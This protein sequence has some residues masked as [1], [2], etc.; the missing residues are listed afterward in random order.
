MAA[1]T[2]AIINKL[3][4]E[5][6]VRPHLKGFKCITAA[7]VLYDKDCNMTDL[8]KALAAG[9]HSTPNRVERNINYL[10]TTSNLRKKSGLKSNGEVIAWLNMKYRQLKE[11][12][13]LI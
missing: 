8:Y 7:I 4:L 10:I 1:T 6:G 2:K 13:G 5:N 3:L 12:R 9:L 11:E